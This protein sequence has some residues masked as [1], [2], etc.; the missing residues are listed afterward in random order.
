MHVTAKADYAIR[1]V[2][3]LS[4]SSQESPRKVDD[5][6]K[7]QN[8]PVS[9]LENILTQLR[10]SGIV[11]S[12]R[13]PEGG[14]WLARAPEDVNLAQ[15]IRAVEGPLVGVRGQ[16]P[17]E[18]EY[19]GSAESLQQVWIAAARKSARG[20]RARDDRRPRRRQAAQK[21]A[22]ADAR[23]GSLADAVAV[24]GQP[25]GWPDAFE[26][27]QS[28]LPFLSDL[29]RFPTRQSGDSAHVSFS[30]ILSSER[31]NLGGSRGRGRGHRRC[32]RPGHHVLAGAEPGP[33]GHPRLGP[34][35]RRRRD[36]PRR[37]RVG[38]ARG[39]SLADHPGGGQDRAI[40]VRGRGAVLRRPHRSRPSAGQRGAVLGRRRHR[41][42]DH[43][44]HPGRG[45][46]LR[47]GH[48]RADRRVDS[49]LLRNPGRRQGRR[50]LRL[51]AQRGLGHLRCAHD[52]Q[53]RR[54][55]ERV[56]DQRAE[57][58]GNQRRHLRRACGDRL[59]RSRAGRP[60][61]RSV[62]G[63]DE[64]GQGHLA[65]HQGVKARSA[66]LAH[67]RCVS[68]RLS[69]ARRI[70]A[71]WQ[72]QA[73]RA[74]SPGARGQEEPVP[75]RDADLRGLPARRSG[76]RRWASPAPPT[77]T[78]WSTPR[79]ASSSA[80]RSSRTSRSRSRWRA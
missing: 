33:E 42:V 29:T 9:F 69:R 41:Y 45:I 11:R 1:A 49:A 77:S 80:G 54:G 24:S 52:G 6:A 53:V 64:R 75:G 36:P 34:W 12:Q 14:Y 7:A 13:G 4:A 8:I 48:W 43:G 35:L 19:V 60:R 17:E 31:Q 62:R 28:G 47:T 46:H 37:S 30:R 3:E 65:G 71:R 25:E 26:F 61:S 55:Q 76:P 5:L 23:R 79:S 73:R 66:R 67:R 57:G 16:R 68:R 39:D 50:I 38:R 27:A 20:A 59:G 63:A 18:I 56:G 74:P 22:G 10:S 51:R 44:H 15:I 32:L 40:R 2:V 70:R 72:G 21:G 78:R 58:V